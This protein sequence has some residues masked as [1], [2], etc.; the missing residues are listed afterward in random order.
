MTIRYF[1]IDPTKNITALATS[2]VSPERYR[3]AAEKIMQK[4]P[5]CEQVGFVYRGE[6][7]DL[8]LDMAGGEFCGNASMSA[9][10]L[11]CAKAGLLPGQ[12]REVSLRVSGADAAVPVRV[13]AKSAA[14]FTCAVTM[15]QPTRIA[16]ERLSFGKKTYALPVVYFPGIAHIIAPETLLPRGAA[17]EAIKG[18]CA[19]LNVKGLGLMLLSEEKQTLTPLVYIPA[20]GTL[21]WESSCASGT[22]AVGAFLSHRDRRAVDLTV[23]EP[24]GALRIRAADKTLRLSGN[25]RLLAEREI[26]I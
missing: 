19:D 11:F 20:A 26:G 18:W 15:P 16:E 22:T 4:E 17:E 24:G 3:E 1:L 6:N 2:P 10:A 21:F 13:T 14:D 9:A 5:S 25:V 7:G 8:C 23:K 12:S